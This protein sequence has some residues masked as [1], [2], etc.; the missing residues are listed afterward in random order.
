[1]EGEQAERWISSRILIPFAAVV[2]LPEIALVLWATRGL[3]MFSAAFF[4]S[5]FVLVPLLAFA[6][7]AYLLRDNRRAIMRERRLGE[8][9]AR[10]NQDLKALTEVATTITESLDEATI[11]ERGL[12][13]LRFGARADSTA[14][15]VPHPEQP[16][17]VGSDGDWDADRAWASPTDLPPGPRSCTSARAACSCACASRPGS[18]RSVP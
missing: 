12:H 1:M 5:A 14:L 10:R 8:Q 16:V 17:L 3:T 6:R 15:H 4:G 9:M 7:Q 2:A 11:V 13:V 18:A